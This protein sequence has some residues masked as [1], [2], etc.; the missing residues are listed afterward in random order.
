MHDIQWCYYRMGS[1]L[2]MNV[3]NLTGKNGISNKFGPPSH[4]S[5]IRVYPILVTVGQMLDV[6]TL[7]N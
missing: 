7:L 5:E 2:T 3:A 4:S 6:A 1:E